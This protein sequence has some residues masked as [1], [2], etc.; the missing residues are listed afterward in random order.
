MTDCKIALWNTRD[1]RQLRRHRYHVRKFSFSGKPNESQEWQNEYMF[2]LERHTD[3]EP[4]AKALM[5]PVADEMDDWND[6]Q[7]WRRRIL[8]DYSHAEEHTGNGTDTSCYLSISDALASSRV[9]PDRERKN[10]PPKRDFNGSSED[11]SNQSEHDDADDE[12]SDGA[13]AA[14]KKSVQVSEL[15]AGAGEE[16]S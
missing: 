1:L 16:K 9:S 7:R 14:R 11:E 12:D 8:L 5:H 6:Y 15:E 4:L 3:Q 13:L 10:E 2:T